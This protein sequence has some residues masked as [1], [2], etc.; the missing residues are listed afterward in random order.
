MPKN[1]QNTQEASKIFSQVSYPRNR[2]TGK[3]ETKPVKTT[4]N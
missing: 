4:E 2:A 1:W 3:V